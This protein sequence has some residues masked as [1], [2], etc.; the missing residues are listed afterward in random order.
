MPFFGFGL[1]SGVFAQSELV[2]HYS[3]PIPLDLLAIVL[4]TGVALPL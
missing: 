3:R 2:R 4:K 1:A